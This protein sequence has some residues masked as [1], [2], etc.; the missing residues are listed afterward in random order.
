MRQVR[1]VFYSF[2][3]ASVAITTGCSVK[4]NMGNNNYTV[5]PNPLE[6]KGDSILITMSANV[7]AKSINPKA[8]LQ[9]QPYLKTPKGDVQLK[10]I[11]IGGEKVTDNVDFK[12]NSKTGGKITYTEKIAYNPDLKRVTL[13]PD[14]AVKM[15][16]EYKTIEAAKGSKV[17]AEGTITTALMVKSSEPSAFDGT[18]YA[19]ST[20]TKQVNIYFPIDVDKFNPKFKMGKMF[21]NKKQIEELK[22][23]LKADKNWVAK[24]ISIN[25]FASPDGELRRNEGLSKG[26][27]SSTFN[28][29]KK[30]LKKLGF[31]EV[32]DQNFSIGYTLSE[33]WA[34]FK[35]LVEESTFA[36]K[37]EILNIVNNT[38]I[39]DEE[40]EGLIR[41]NHVKSWEKMKTT[42]LPK[43]RR[44]ELVV[45]GQT[46]LKSDSELVAISNNNQLDQLSDVEILHLAAI[47]TDAD[48]KAALYNAYQVRFPNDWRGFNDLGAVYLSQGKNNE[49]ATQLNKANELSPENGTVLANL[50]VVAKNKGDYA[51][52][53]KYYT[54]AAA[55]GT[56]VSYH[57]GVLAI[58]K[59]N[60]ADAMTNFN[61][62]GKK[63]F[64]YALAQLLNGDAN[65]AKATLDNM[66]P[67]D[68]TWDCYYLRAICGAR[69]GNADQTA[70]N[71]T[72]AVQLN[73]SVRAMAKEDVEFIKM[74]GTP[75]FDGSIR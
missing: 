18:E 8:N 13:Y 22:T 72:R 24:G 56:D 68:M 60:Y 75:A 54:Q 45:K 9:F 44:S 35:K 52:A 46:P 28:Y 21:D 59:G 61:K 74:W 15:G 16:T 71:L 4:T 66:K 36:D 70:A 20:A 12:I 38:T 55:K 7:P 53:E 11:T 34:G 37:N 48:K 49:A 65:A 14:F 6:V 39:S 47:T 23:L 58:K 29:F 30:E 73:S 69:A 31:T 57:R 25:A 33:D 32:N 3:F 5:S 17:L 26:R 62:A 19:A 10:A 2:L 27:S 67:E 50:G 41:R 40:K 63:D 42:L 51:G 64:N 1:Q 43:L